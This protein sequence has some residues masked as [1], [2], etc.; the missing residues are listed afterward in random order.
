MLAGVFFGA[1]QKFMRQ[2][3]YALKTQVQPAQHQ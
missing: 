3:F 2:F 1:V